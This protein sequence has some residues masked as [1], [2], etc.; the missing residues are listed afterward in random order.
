MAVS[1]VIPSVSFGPK[2][3]DQ[4]RSQFQLQT[5][6]FGKTDL[7]YYR[8]V[9]STNDVA[10]ALALAGCPEG[11]LVVAESQT[12]GRGRLGRKWQSPKG[13]LYF[14]L[15]LRP[16]FS[17]SLAPRITLLAG[18]AVC[19]AISSVARVDGAIKW[20]NDILIHGKKVAG[21]LTETEA[22]EG[23]LRHAIVGVGINVNTDTSSL[24]PE[25]L[26]TA[27][28][29]SGETQETVSIEGLLAASLMEMEELWGQFLCHGFGPIREAWRS[30]SATLGRPACFRITGRE[31]AGLA[32]DIDQAPALLIRDQ[33]G[34]IHKICS[35]EVT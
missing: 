15:V 6:S 8:E 1:N 33:H 20:P 4:P 28:S 13:G 21:I 10:R 11:T 18:V 12:A 34:V 27:G 29:I 23:S 3:V 26:E 7:H 17:P 24:P 19:R 30:L 2:E 5:R 35:G 25:L 16:T 9:G 14:S 32:L 31:I 22:K